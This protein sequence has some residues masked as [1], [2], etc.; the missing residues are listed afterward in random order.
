MTE[1]PTL[2]TDR[3]ILRPFTVD[4]A[5]RVQELAGARAI[6]DTT[7][8]IPH[9]YPDGAAEAWI[10]TH[11]AEFEAGRS[12]VFAVVLRATGVLIGAIGLVI[13]SHDARAEM[14][15]WIGKPFWNHGYATDAG[16]AVLVYAFNQLGLHRVH[17]SYMSRNPASGRVMEKLGMRHEG[18]LRQ[19]VRKWDAFEDLEVRGIL[20]SEFEG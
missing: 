7:A 14:G 5:Q 2:E 8:N 18:R 16:H 3:L 15:Y 11:A 10:G 12:V 1:R 20:R 4:D 6:A 17:A 13:D 9:P 19:H